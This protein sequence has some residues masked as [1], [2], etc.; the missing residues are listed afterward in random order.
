MRDF[1][2][3]I[4]PFLAEVSMLSYDMTPGNET[5]VYYADGIG[6]ICS[7]ICFD[8]I[9]EELTIDS[10]RDGAELILLSTNDSWFKDSVAIYMH[11][12]QAKLRS[13]ET[14]RCTIRAACTG[15]S[16]IITDTADTLSEVA[17]F[18]EGYAFAEVTVSSDLTLYT[19]TG[20][21]L[22]Y[23]IAALAAIA[24]CYEFYLSKARKSDFQDQ[25]EAM[26]ENE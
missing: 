12:S 19:I 1:L 22:I 10:V 8:S 6:S 3:V 9:Y 21:L 15:V 2:T 4:F 11:S 20:N 18:E 14:G 17:V 24:F 25:V 16:Q 23:L 7:I 13:I 26:T 5:D